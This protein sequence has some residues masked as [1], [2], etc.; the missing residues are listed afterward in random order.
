M[1]VSAA[2]RSKAADDVRDVVL[3]DGSTLRL[4][5]PTRADLDAVIA[6][7]SGL[8]PESMFLRFHGFAKV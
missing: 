5:P 1:P 3:R 4:R 7:F 2:L 8:S 6:F